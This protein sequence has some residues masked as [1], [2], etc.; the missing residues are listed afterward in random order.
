[1]FR[2]VEVEPMTITWIKDISKSSQCV[3]VLVL[4]EYKCDLITSGQYGEEQEMRIHGDVLW[5]AMIW[6]HSFRAPAYQAKI[7]GA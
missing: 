4:V 5:L 7:E 1:M 6:L 2:G 3:P